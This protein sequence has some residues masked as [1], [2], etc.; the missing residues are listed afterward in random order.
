M[1]SLCLSFFSFFFFQ[2]NTFILFIL[3]ICWIFL[4]LFSQLIPSALLGLPCL[5]GFSL[6]AAGGGSSVVVVGR[7]SLWWPLIL[8]SPGQGT[9]VVV[10]FGLCWPPA[11][12][13]P[14]WGI[15]MVF[16]AL[17]VDSWAVSH[18]RNPWWCFDWHFPDDEHVWACFP[19]SVYFSKPCESVYLLQWASG[20]SAIP[21]SCFDYPSPV[22]SWGQMTLT[23]P[24]RLN[25]TELNWKTPCECAASVSPGS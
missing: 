16:P 21:E 3:Y 8:G 10:S 7:L 18:P 13:S 19:L 6:G 15:D 23:A 17:Q 12:G 11:Y 22:M 20:M 4:Y 5:P 25:W 24:E 2:K 9:G 1:T 14:G